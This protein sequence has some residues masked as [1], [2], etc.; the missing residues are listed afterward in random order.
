MP[1]WQRTFEPF[2]KDG[3]LAIAGIVQE[4]HADRARL[5]AQWRGI[6]WPILVDSLN[7]Y[8]NRVVPIVM[9]VDEAGRVAVV[10]IRSK[11]QLEALLAAPAAKPARREPDAL[12]SGAAEFLAGDWNGAVRKFA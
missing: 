5:Y 3:K 10:G 8:G 7:L 1:G 6:T 11:A 2:L 9:G 4:Q 12:P